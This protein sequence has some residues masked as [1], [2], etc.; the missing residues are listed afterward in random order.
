[1]FEVFKTRIDQEHTLYLYIVQKEKINK[2]F[3]ILSNL[4]FFRFSSHYYSYIYKRTKK[5][6]F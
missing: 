1:M 3:L 6:F 2:Q 4:C 5:Q